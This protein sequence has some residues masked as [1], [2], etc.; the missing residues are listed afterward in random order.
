MSRGR[1][2]DMKKTV[3][4][5]ILILCAFG[6]SSCTNMINSINAENFYNGDWKNTK[7]TVSSTSSNSSSNYSI[8]DIYTG[9]LGN[10]TTVRFTYRRNYKDISYRLEANA[11]DHSLVYERTSSGTT[12]YFDSKEVS[13]INSSDN[14]SLYFVYQNLISGTSPI[15]PNHSKFTKVQR[16]R[17][18]EDTSGLSVIR[19]ATINGSSYTGTLIFDN[20]NIKY[21]LAYKGYFNGSSINLNSFSFNGTEITEYTINSFIE[22]SDFS[23]SNFVS[24]DAFL[25]ID[26]CVLE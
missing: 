25:F 5:T 22:D 12:L 17:I 19:K 18:V 26:W 24:Y 9:T 16:I 15:N 13:R 14:A 21:D 20:G 11:D 3:T 6:L 2:I 10:N 4:A 23:I 7:S 8:L 1:K